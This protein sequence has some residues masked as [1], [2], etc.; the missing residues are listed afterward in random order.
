MPKYKLIDLINK[1]KRPESAPVEAAAPRLPDPPKVRG[2]ARPPAEKSGYGIWVAAALAVFFLFFALTF[3][4]AQATIVIVPK[5]VAINLNE[6]M[7][8]R[9]NDLEA[10]LAYDVVALSG[11]EQTTILSSGQKDLSVPAKGVV[12]IYNAFSSSPQ[13]LAINTRLEGSNGKIYKTEKALTVPGVSGGKPG[14]VSANIYATEPGE[15]YNSE[16]LDFKIFGFK[17]TPKYGKFYGRSKGPI[18]GGFAGMA[19]QVSPEDKD[20]AFRALKNTLNEKLY[21]KASAQI[22]AGFILWP[23]AAVFRVDE[24][25]AD[26]ASTDAEVPAKV[27]GTLTGYLFDQKKLTEQI[28]QKEI[29]GYDGGDIYISNIKNLTFTLLASGAEKDVINFSLAGDAKVVYKLDEVKLLADLLGKKKSALPQILGN[30]PN[31]AEAK[32]SVRPFW[33]LSFP[34]KPDKIRIIVQYPQN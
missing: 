18:T 26:L 27:K 20:S 5:T 15:D 21:Q 13:P 34:D 12:I 16:P 23:G 11:V 31:V 2:T 8:A 22:P 25:Y 29:V 19:R 17:G 30:Y 6:N 4:F 1:G 33:K 14:Q 32:L 28:A 10:P 7:T 24:E 3:L 9:Y